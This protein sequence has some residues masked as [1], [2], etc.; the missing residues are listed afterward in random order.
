MRRWLTE[1]P[2][3]TWAPS[4]HP[5][6]LGVVFSGFDYDSSKREITWG[7]DTG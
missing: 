7:P 1:K 2:L 5:E 3:S 4:A 6:C